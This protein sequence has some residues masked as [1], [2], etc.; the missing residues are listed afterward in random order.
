MLFCFVATSRYSSLFKIKEP[1]YQN[2]SS[3]CPIVFDLFKINFHKS[4]SENKI[5]KYLIT[6]LASREA[7]NFAPVTSYRL[8]DVTIRSA[9]DIMIDWVIQFED[10][11]L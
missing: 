4:R 6:P 11:N 3:V 5:P 7:H 1:G 8:Y 10:C 9:D 2:K